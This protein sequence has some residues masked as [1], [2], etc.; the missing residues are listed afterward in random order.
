MNAELS[1]R[2]KTVLYGLL[3]VLLVPFVTQ[4]KVLLLLSDSNSDLYAATYDGTS[5]VLT[6]SG[7]ALETSLSSIAT[8]PFW[9]ANQGR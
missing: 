5:W 9:F 3:C 1:P 8:M 7:A 6:N 4:S 2:A